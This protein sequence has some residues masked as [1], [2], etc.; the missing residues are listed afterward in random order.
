MRL[1]GSAGCPPRRAEGLADGNIYIGRQTLKPEVAWSAEAGI[2]V[3]AG[4]MTF[5]PSLF[6]RRI[7]GYVQGTPVPA[8]MPMQIAIA[9]MNG[10]A[11]PLIA[12]NVDA[13]LYGADAD[14]SWQIAPQLRLDGTISYVR[15]QRRD[16]ADN[17][18][19]IAPLNGRLALSWD[20]GVWSVTGEMVGAA[21]QSK[22]SLTNGEASSPGWV[23]ANLWF[24]VDLGRHISLSGGVENLFDRRYAD[25]LAGRN[26][27]TLSD[28]AL[29]EK[30]PAAGR[31]LFVRLG[32][33]F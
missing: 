13:E 26:R 3:M 8:T 6:Y 25:H 32:F 27:V 24:G 14:L 11:T 1:S 10:D 21:S 16:I 33:D 4:P 2:D 22:V 7:D 30:L 31:S 12:T 17:L 29:G 15:G 5:R 19:R 9:T 18:Y 28:V 20:G 23:S